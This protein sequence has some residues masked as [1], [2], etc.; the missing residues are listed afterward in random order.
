MF[1]TFIDDLPALD[2]PFPEDAVSA[3]G[4]RS[5][6]GLVVFF[7]FHKDVTLPEHSH[8]PQ[9]GTLVAGEITMTIDGTTRSMHPG[10]HWDIPANVPHGAHI[11]AGSVIIDVF[12]EPDRFLFRGEAAR[13]HP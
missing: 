9:W 3:R 12:A 8:G 13:D 4:M 7:T 11:A 2:L 6:R 5:D 10:D 1:A